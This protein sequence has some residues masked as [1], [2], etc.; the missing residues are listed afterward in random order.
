MKVTVHSAI[1]DIPPA[2]WNALCGGDYPFLR[3]EFL[4]AA[5]A[6][7]SVSPEAGWT[8]RHLTLAGSGGVRAAMPL[9]EKSHSWGEFVFDW[10]WA[11]AYAQ[12]GYRYYPK[13]VP[14]IVSTLLPPGK[15]P[16][17]KSLTGSP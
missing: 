10:A 17:G 4:Q 1:A 9:Y 16:I 13:L 14:A 3:H 11:Q 6:S 5:E 2:D 7:G 12:A 8:P 15:V